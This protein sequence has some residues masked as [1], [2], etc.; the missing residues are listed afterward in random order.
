[1]ALTK[2]LFKIGLML[3]V[4]TGLVLINGY[5]SKASGNEKTVVEKG[6]KVKVHY[7]GSLKDG[8]VFDNSKEGKGLVF[9]IK[10]VGIE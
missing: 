3:V 7:T 1:M 4:I 9:D 5:L 10:I 6:N 8:S 2:I